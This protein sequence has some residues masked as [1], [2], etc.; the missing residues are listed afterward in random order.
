M[1]SGL[2]MD[3]AHGKRVVVQRTRAGGLL[4]ERTVKE[5]AV[6]KDG[7]IELV[8]RSTNAK[9]KP[10]RLTEGIGADEQGVIVEIDGLVI[11]SYRPE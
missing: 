8:P 6:R 9:W 7:T 4:R 2:T 1:R 10:F 11:G 5:I 3:E